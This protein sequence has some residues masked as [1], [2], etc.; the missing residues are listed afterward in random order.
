[1]ECGSAIPQFGVRCFQIV[2][3]L[4]I[5]YSPINVVAVEKRSSLSFLRTM[6]ELYRHDRVVLSLD[7][8][9]H[10]I[11]PG[12]HIMDRLSCD[13]GGGWFEARHAPR[14]DDAIAQISMTS[15]TTGASKAMALSHRALGD[16]TDRLIEVMGLDDTVSEYVGVPVTYSFGF[17]RVRAVSAVG[18]RVF[19]P[20]RS[21]RVDEFATMLGQEEVNALS[22]VPSLL[23]VVLAQA[24]RIRPIGKKLRWLEIGSQAMSRP[25]KEAIREL[26]PNARIVQHYGLT[27]ASR[28]TFLRVSDESGETLSSVGKP[29]GKVEIRITPEGHIAIRGPHV[30]DGIVTTSGIDPIIDRD[31]WLVTGDLGHI[32]DGRLYFDGRADHLVNVGGIKVPA[33]AFE[34]K[35]LAR[36]GANAD[37]AC[38]GGKDDL[39]GEILVIAHRIANATDDLATLR[40][41]ASDVA[42][43]MNIRDGFSLIAMGTIPRTETNK[44]RRH[45]IGAL[46]NEQRRVLVEQGRIEPGASTDPGT[47]VRTEF[48]TLFGD[49]LKDG[50]DSFASL[51][52]D[53]LQYVVMMLALERHIRQLPEGWDI[54]PVDDLAA[55]ADKQAQSD[56]KQSAARLVPENLNSVRGLACVMIVALHVVGVSADEGLRLPLESLW[57][58]IMDTFT[59]IRL[60]LFTA[61]SGFLYAAMPATRDGFSIFAKRKL[62]QLLIPLIFATLVFWSL[63]QVVFDRNDSLFWA[64]VDGYQHLWF[65]D[66]LLL[67]FLLVG[68]I[69]T[70]IRSRIAIWWGLIAAIV[71]LYP[72]VPN[73]PVLHIKN[74]LF[75]LPFFIFGILLYR[76]P[77]LLR[78]PWLVGGSLIALPALLAAQFL[79]LGNGDAISLDL[80]SRW[81]CGAVAVIVFLRFFPRFGWLESLAVYSFTIYLWHPAANGL[82]RTLAWEAGL[83]NVPVMFTIGLAAGVLLPVLLHKVMLRLPGISPVVIGR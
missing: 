26:F 54:W 16:V 75:Q 64:F 59:P 29:I 73:V 57:H 45:E 81:L 17:G 82:V 23:R 41:A 9:A 47:S 2:G 3:D 18:G 22:A 31:G 72:F 34:E 15:G 5:S 53:S 20:P 70:T 4:T 55:L 7:L 76:T 63:R 11:T 19:L 52:G 65:I 12:L 36:L 62:Q 51:G 13:A 66:A 6:F 49:R 48:A 39:R 56:L 32:D 61:L 24:D 43:E 46:F 50:R 80:L 69:D 79:S 33:E 25:E 71:V 28:S 1:V 67:I 42:E 10:P 44:V 60:P 40:R 37:I 74:A 83:E 58:T 14:H 77:N 21:F 27:E 38:A 35:L 30:A 68:L 8:A 78:N